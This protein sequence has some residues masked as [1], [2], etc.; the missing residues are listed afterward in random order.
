MREYRRDLGHRD[1]RLAEAA[2]AGAPARDRG[3]ARR[4]GLRRRAGRGLVV[5][6]RAA[7][8]RLIERP[9]FA[10]RSGPSLAPVAGRALQRATSST[11]PTRSSATR[12]AP[13]STSASSATAGSCSRVRPGSGRRSRGISPASPRSTCDRSAPAAA[14]SPGSTPAGCCGSAPTAPAPIPGPAC[15]GRGGERPTVTDAAAVLGYLDP[16]RF[17]G[18]KMALDVGRGAGGDRAARAR[19]WGSSPTPRRARS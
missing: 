3:R 1:R 15:Y 18:G 16:D 13:A 12:A 14:R 7:D 2:D 11:A 9:I 5:R 8:G 10:A 19:R 6:R 4:G 17:L